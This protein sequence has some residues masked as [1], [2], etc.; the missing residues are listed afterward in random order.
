MNEQPTDTRALILQ[1]LDGQWE[2]I[3]CALIF[4]LSRNAPVVISHSD[5]ERLGEF[6]KSRQ[7]L[8]WGHHD[9]IEL[10]LVT[11]ERG[12]EIVKHIESIG[13]RVERP[14]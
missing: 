13:G 1:Q 6:M 7:L 3:A 5:L 12:A 11:P 4:K 2:K 14:S 8:T 9:S 10:R